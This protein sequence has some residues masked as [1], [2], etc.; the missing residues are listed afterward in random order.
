MASGWGSHTSV[1]AAGIVPAGSQTMFL[2]WIGESQQV[3]SLGTED[4]LFVDDPQK[5]YAYRCE[6]L[7]AEQVRLQKT[8]P[9]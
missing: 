5:A 2:R 3:L 7:G 6:R 9:P 1:I 4:S 8:L